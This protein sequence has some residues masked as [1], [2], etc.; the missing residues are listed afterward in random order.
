MNQDGLFAGLRAAVPQGAILR[1]EP[2]WRHTSFRIGGPAEFYIQPSGEAELLSAI[3][4]LRRAGQ[5]YIVIGNGTNLLV[6]D[7]GIRGVVIEAGHGCS[8]IRIQDTAV[9]A[10]AGILLSRLANAALEHGLSGLEFAAGIPGSL[11]GAVVMNAGAYGG[12]M[13]DVVV[14]TRYFDGNTGEVREIAGA[15]HQFGYR[16]SVFGAGDVVLSAQM[17]LSHGDKAE[18]AALMKDLNQRRK[19]KQPI[20]LPS[21]GSTF[22]RPE[23]QFAGKLIADAGLAG[24]RVGGACVSEKH[25]GFVVNDKNATCAD[26]RRLMEHIQQVVYERFGVELEPEVRFL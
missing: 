24:Y 23:G 11:G 16:K 12:E 6:H 7:A 15:A 3:R 9:T 20:E 14:R 19:D 1:E 17:E 4:F 26:V 22:K 13:K 21:A 10:E 25:C 8:A 18:I 2:M 5:P